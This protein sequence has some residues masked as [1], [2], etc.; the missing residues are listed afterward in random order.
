M[1]NKF[2]AG[3][4]IAITSAFAAQAET[5]RVPTSVAIETGDTWIS[6]GA[7]YRLYGVQACVR[8]T[9]FI[10]QPGDPSD[11]GN[12]SIATL[13]ALIFT[14]TMSCQTITVSKEKISLVVCAAMLGDVAVDVGT[15]LISSG[16]A[17]AALL[18]SGD[19]VNAAY[20]VAELA[21]KANK[22]GLWHGKFD[23]PNDL[24]FKAR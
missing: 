12:Q 22:A 8:G 13:A 17:F 7:K 3:A 2:S 9:V 16:S 14:N 1:L 24:L 20:L 19:P 5:I 18:P 23:H 4:L 21:A 10:D 11:C 15:A 6:D